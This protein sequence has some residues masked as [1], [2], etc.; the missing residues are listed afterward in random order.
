MTI[1]HRESAPSV[2][3]AGIKYNFVGTGCVGCGI[4]HFPGRVI[5]A[6]C[7]GETEKRAFSGLGI[8]ESFTVI[9]AVPAGFSSPLTVAI[10]R[11]DEGITISGQVVG[12]PKTRDQGVEK[13]PDSATAPGGGGGPGV[14]VVGSRVRAVFR[15][16]TES[17]AGLIR[18]GYKFELV[19]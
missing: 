8:I 16:L 5:C 2:W 9:N 19:G 15:K 7:G 3:R 13:G 10:V 1:P 14:V 4:L 17:S 12:L 18:Y 6:D 11:L